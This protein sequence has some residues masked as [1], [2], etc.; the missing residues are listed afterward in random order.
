MAIQIQFYT[1][2]DA[3]MHGDFKEKL[4]SIFNVFKILKSLEILLLIY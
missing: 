1:V 2:K 3:M 4:V